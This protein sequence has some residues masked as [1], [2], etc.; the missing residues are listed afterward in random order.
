MEN[1]T[2][3]QEQEV[4]TRRSVL[5]IEPGESRCYYTGG[6]E[7]C[8]QTA[9]SIASQATRITGDRYTTDT[10]YLKGYIRITRQEAAGAGKEGQP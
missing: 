10:G 6:D 5:A 9:R 4:C 8:I 3:T 2:I 7:R 1:D